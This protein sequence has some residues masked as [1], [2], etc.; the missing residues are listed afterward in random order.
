MAVNVAPLL[1]AQDLSVLSDFLLFAITLAFVA[2]FHRHTL[3]IALI[4]L[5]SIIVK[6][7]ASTGFAEGARASRSLRAFR[8]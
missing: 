4:G 2:I 1:G 7:L 3:A 8:A 5:A 6:K